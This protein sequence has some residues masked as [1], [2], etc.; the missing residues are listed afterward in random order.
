MTK[1]ELLSQLWAMEK[2]SPVTSISSPADLLPVLQEYA[3]STVEQF[4]VASL[5]GAHELIS[6]AE[7]TKGLVNRTMV[8]PREI[9]RKAI[10]D[11]ATAI[12]L[13]HNHPS[14]NVEP[15]GDDNAVTDRLTRAGELIGIQVLDHLIISCKGFYSYLEHGGMK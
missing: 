2:E 13:V 9:F 6:I 14:G 7:I 1:R 8:H 11:N 12:V 5:N 3:R 10:I 4:V 15:S